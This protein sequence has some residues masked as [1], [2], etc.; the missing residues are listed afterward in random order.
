MLLRDQTSSA[1]SYIFVFDSREAIERAEEGLFSC[2]P[3]STERI[4]IRN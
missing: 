4:K 2:T 1:V 3:T